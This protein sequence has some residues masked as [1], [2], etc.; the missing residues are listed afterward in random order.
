M[1]IV[2]TTSALFPEPPNN[3]SY[4]VALNREL[5]KL[6]REVGFRLAAIEYTLKMQPPS[7]KGNTS[8]AADYA[9][10]TVMDDPVWWMNE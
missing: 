1:T 10:Y 3:N 5:Y 2:N 7:W 4:A 9:V 8:G 6:S